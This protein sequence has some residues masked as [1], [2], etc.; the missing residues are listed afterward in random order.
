MAVEMK[1]MLDKG[2]EAE[3]LKKIEAALFVS[4][5][6]LTLQDLIMLTDI[7]PILI[8]QLMEKLV[9]RYVKEESGIEILSRGE[10]WKMDVKKEHSEM[11]N[12]LATGSAE[13]SKAEQSTL[14]IIAYK[15]PVKQSVLVKIRGNKAYE[16]VKKFIQ[17]GLIKAKKLG[18]T[19]ELTLSQGFYDYFKISKSSDFDNVQNSA[20]SD[21]NKTNLKQ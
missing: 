8:K 9:E 7:N 15:Q 6:W 14:A 20:N 2:K 18:R 19:K 12:R 10:R 4:G 17:L 5:K 21:I 11:V 13:F 3:Y 16:H 1:G